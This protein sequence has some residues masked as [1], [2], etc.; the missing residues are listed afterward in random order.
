MKRRC[1]CASTASRSGS[2]GPMKRASIHGESSCERSGERHGPEHQ[3]RE[4]ALRP[5]GARLVG[6]RDEDVVVAGH[7]P[8]PPRAVEVVVAIL[9]SHVRRALVHDPESWHQSRRDDWLTIWSSKWFEDSIRKRSPRSS[10]V[11][12]NAVSSIPRWRSFPALRSRP[13]HVGCSPT[14]RVWRPRSASPD[15]RWRT[16]TSPTGPTWAESSPT[17]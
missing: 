7:E 15:F 12:A 14:S 2:I 9:P 1:R 13:R 17:R 3:C 10:S 4:D 6:G 16:R 5:G 8:I 11:S